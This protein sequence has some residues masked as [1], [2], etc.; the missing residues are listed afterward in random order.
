MSSS[1]PILAFQPEASAGI[2]A[3]SAGVAETAP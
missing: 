2:V 1:F 3:A